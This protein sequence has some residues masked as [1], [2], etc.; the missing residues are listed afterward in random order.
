MWYL[1]GPTAVG[2]SEIA[3]ELAGRLNAEIITADSMQVYRG[4]DIGTAKPTV[5]EQAQVRHHLLDVA[6]VEETYDVARYRRE[7]LQVVPDILGRGKKPLVVGGSG[8]YVRALR[9]GL[10]DGCKR[11]P[12]IRKK[13]LSIG[14][15]KGMSYLHHILERVDAASASRIAPA[16][17]RRVV[18]AL[19]H[20]EITGKPISSMQTQWGAAASC[21]I[22]IGL[23]RPRETLHQRCNQRVLE[24]LKKGFLDEVSGLLDRLEKSGTAGQAVGYREAVDHL[25]GRSTREEMVDLI[26]THTRQLA[27]RQLTWFRRE[28]NLKWINIEDGQPTSEITSQLAGIFLS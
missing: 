6:E 27:K 3:L 9:L 5:G 15:N 12:E 19:E 1:V 16:D 4:M 21:D 13:W 28:H 7:V 22:I 26:Q 24:M 23:D 17:T 2:K 11:D 20:F 8:M 18:R 10:F 14:E 25:R